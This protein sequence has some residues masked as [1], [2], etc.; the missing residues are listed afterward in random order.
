MFTTTRFDDWNL[1]ANLQSGLDAAGWT[2]A[3]QVQKDTVPIA[4]S[5][6]DVIGQARTGSGKT[7]AFGLPI[8]ER[9]DPTGQLQAQIQNQTPNNKIRHKKALNCRKVYVNQTGPCLYINW[10]GPQFGCTQEPLKRLCHTYAL[11]EIH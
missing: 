8:L 7:A 4:R 2:F 5:G 9:C 10:R 11:H 1:P 3:T 6:R